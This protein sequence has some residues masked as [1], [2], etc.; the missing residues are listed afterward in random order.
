MGDSFKTE[1][2]IRLATIEDKAT[3][4]DF[5]Y[6]LDKVEHVELARAEKISKAILDKHCFI[7]LQNTIAVGFLIFDYRFFDHG[8]I[9]LIIVEEKHRGRGIAGKA[10]LLLCEK[11]I[12]K[13]VFTSTN[14]S[15][16][17][18]QRDLSKTG[19]TFAG[20]LIGLVEGDPELFYFKEIKLQKFKPSN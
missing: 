18:M 2:K 9:E 14:R 6:N 20:E 4:I 17:K 8:W 1:I 19:F 7:I 12:S 11:C 15:N 16:I 3:A 10:I 13:K 5:D